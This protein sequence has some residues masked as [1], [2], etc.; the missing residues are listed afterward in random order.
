MALTSLSSERMRDWRSRMS[1]LTPSF[2]VPSVALWVWFPVWVWLSWVVSV[3]FLPRVSNIDSQSARSGCTPMMTSSNGNIF[4]VTWPFVRG[5]HR[6][7]VNSLHRGQWR[8]ALRVFFD[9]RLNKRLSK[10]SW[11]WWFETPSRPLW[12]HCNGILMMTSSHRND[13]IHIHS[14]FVREVRRS[15]VV[16]LTHCQW[17]EASMFYLLIT[18][19]RWWTNSRFV[20]NDLDR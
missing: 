1:L 8:A 13:W 10:Q 15:S 14:P 4:R 9:L 5:I 11:G 18:W 16:F 6:S 20:D 17:C 19:T 12:C 7:P 3:L 2:L